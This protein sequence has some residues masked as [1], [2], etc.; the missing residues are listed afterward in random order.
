MWVRGSTLGRR[1]KAE[2]GQGVVGVSVAAASHPKPGERE[3]RREEWR[4]GERR[5]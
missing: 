1:G 2:E 3:G 4:G 5:W